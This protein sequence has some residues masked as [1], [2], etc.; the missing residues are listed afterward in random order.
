MASAGVVGL[1]G[2]LSG[3]VGDRFDRRH[4]MVTT[5]LAAAAGWAGFVLGMLA[6][7]LIVTAVGARTTDL[8]PGGL[9]AVG[10]VAADG[11]RR[12]LTVEARPSA[13]AI[14]DAVEPGPPEG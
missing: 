12:R 4:V 6:A 5:E 8:V 10:A 14:S 11:L 7:G 13:S 9:L 1:V 3:W 2:P